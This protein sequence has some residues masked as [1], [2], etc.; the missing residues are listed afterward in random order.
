MTKK[1]TGGIWTG[2]RPAN[3]R[4]TGAL[5]ASSQPASLP[6][7]AACAG[8]VSALTP[9]GTR[10]LRG[11]RTHV[12][13]G[14]R[15]RTCRTRLR[16]AGRRSH[17]PHAMAGGTAVHPEEE[18]DEGESEIE[19]LHAPSPPTEPLPPVQ[20]RGRKE[21][22]RARPP[23]LTHLR[24]EPT[25]AAG[26]GRAAAAVAAAAAA[27]SPEKPPLTEIIVRRRT[28]SRASSVACRRRRR[29]CLALT[30]CTLL[31]PSTHS[32]VGAARPLDPLRAADA[33]QRGAS[34]LVWLFVPHS[35]GAACEREGGL[36]LDPRDAVRCAEGDV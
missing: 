36:G 30:P 5:P 29:V 2:R 26:G 14:S 3:D 11:E 27:P 28:A 31:A 34:R 23:E 22:Q 16:A 35:A 33:E 24:A 10:T 25:G 19:A 9:L 15:S 17:A 8:I 6:P 7:A 12:S 13:N 1:R 32:G 18:E 4:W 20:P 21:P